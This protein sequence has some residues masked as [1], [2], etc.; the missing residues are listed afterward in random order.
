L[1]AHTV[2]QRIDEPQVSLSDSV[3]LVRRNYIVW[4]G[5]ADDALRATGVRAAGGGIVQ[6]T[7]AHRSAETIRRDN[8]A[9]KLREIAASLRLIGNCSRGRVRPPEAESSV[10]RREIQRLLSAVKYM[11]Y[12][13]RPSRVESSLHSMCVAQGQYSARKHSRSFDKQPTGS[14]GMARPHSTTEAGRMH[15][16]DYFKM[17]ALAGAAFSPVGEQ[18]LTAQEVAARRGIPPVKITEIRTIQTRPGAGIYLPAPKGRE[19]RTIPL[20]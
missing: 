1:N 7:L 2:R 15:R 12:V 14:W 17:M 8:G 13:D 11:R 4:V 16:R 5:I 6:L 9:Q 19:Y 18:F 3:Q 10:V 20:Q